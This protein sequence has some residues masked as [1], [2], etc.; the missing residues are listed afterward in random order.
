MASDRY[1]IGYFDGWVDVGGTKKPVFVVGLAATPDFMAK[2]SGS[3]QDAFGTNR[4]SYN[5]DEIDKAGAVLAGGRSFTTANNGIEFPNT[6]AIFNGYV[7]SDFPATAVISVRVMRT[8]SV[9]A[10]YKVYSAD[11]TSAW[12]I[13]AYSPVI[14]SCVTTKSVGEKL[15]EFS[16]TR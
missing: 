8:G 10:V 15:A 3:S 13:S 9:V 6:A 16:S 1:L 4:H 11:G 5:G 2:I 7:T 12:W 14:V